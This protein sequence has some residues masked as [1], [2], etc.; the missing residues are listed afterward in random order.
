MQENSDFVKNLYSLEQRNLSRVADALFPETKTHSA[1]ELYD[2]RSA[3]RAKWGA[4]EREIVTK[5]FLC[6]P[7]ALLLGG[8]C[9]SSFAH[10]QDASYAWR[11]VCTLGVALSIAGVTIGGANVVFRQLFIRMDDTD[12]YST[13]KGFKPSASKSEDCAVYNKA[14][15]KIDKMIL[16]LQKKRMAEPSVV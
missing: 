9:L 5:D 4:A 1:E 2:A 15:R 6:V 14:E 12:Q 7:A 11:T 8:A 3:I 13:D 16:K 10:T